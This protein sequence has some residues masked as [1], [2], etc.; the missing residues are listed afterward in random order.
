MKIL[1]VED[2]LI[3]AHTLADMLSNMGY[4]SIR[5]EPSYEK[6]RKLLLEENYIL[7]ILDINLGKGEEG[8]ELAQICQQRKTPF[9]Y[10][11]SYTD[12]MTLD[13]ALQTSPGAYLIKPITESNLYTTVQIV[14]DKEKTKEDPI[15]EFKDGIETIRIPLSKILY[16]K[17]ENIYVNVISNG[18]IYLYRGSLSSFIEKVPQGKLVQTHRAF[19]VNPDHVSRIA[20]TYVIVDGVEIPVSRSFK[21]QFVRAQA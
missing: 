6:A 2:E 19:V 13:K 10:T 8:L 18:K 7:T 5:V 17:A 1:I 9:I 21:N 4:K 3:L 14:L 12:K 20:A 11:S 15:L 16:L